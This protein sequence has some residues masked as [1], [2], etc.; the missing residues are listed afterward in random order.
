MNCLLDHLLSTTLLLWWDLSPR[1]P[2]WM[3]R[4]FPA[5]PLQENLPS[6]PIKLT[7]SP[8]SPGR[9]EWM[10]RGFLV[11]PS[12]DNLLN[13]SKW[14]CRGFP[15]Y[16]SQDHLLNKPIILTGPALSPGRPEQTSQVFP[17][18]TAKWT[19]QDHAATK[20]IILT[21]SCHLLRE[22]LKALSPL[23]MV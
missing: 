13:K 10:C 12:Q 16:L 19:F 8:L 3:C 5:C 15:V 1:R 9:P 11:Y 23:R 7:Q 17:S 6:K 14:M 4:D 21:R 22:L 2:E 18:V 20:I